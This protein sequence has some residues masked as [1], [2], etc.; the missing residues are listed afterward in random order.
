MLESMKVLLQLFFASSFLFWIPECVRRS[1]VLQC[2]YD[3]YIGLRN[4]PTWVAS[5][6][7]TSESM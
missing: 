6:H 2:N 4:G 7:E 1:V 5:T 3:E